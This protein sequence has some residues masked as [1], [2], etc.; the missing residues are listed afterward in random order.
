MTDSSSIGNKTAKS[1]K[2]IAQQ[3]AKQMLNEPFEVLKTSGEQ[4]AGVKKNEPFQVKRQKEQSPQTIEEE[5]NVDNAKSKRLIQALE[6]ELEDVRKQKEQEEKSKEAV[7]A[8]EKE[9]E[10]E[11]ESQNSPLVE[12]STK[13]RKGGLKGFVEKVK[14]RTET[15]LPPSG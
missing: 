1:A 10:F 11:I 15:R 8:Q 12:P 13:P 14:K 6:N 4:V 9:E 7:E 5:K 2:K 3:A